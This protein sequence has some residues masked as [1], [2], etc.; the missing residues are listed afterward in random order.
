MK[1]SLPNAV[2]TRVAR[3]VLVAQKHSPKIMF[4]SGLVLMGG[5]VVAACKGTLQLETTLDEVRRDREDVA[6][7]AERHPE[8]YTEREVTKLNAYVTVKGGVRIVKLYL[9][10]IALGVAAVACL[11][12]SHNQLTRR[13]AGLSAALAATERALDGYR[14]RVRESLG[15]D[16]ELELWRGE[17]TETKVVLDDEGRETKSKVKVKTGGGYSPYARVWGRDTS[18]EWDPI[19]EYNLAKLRSVQSWGTIMLNSR[20]HLFLN[21]I[22]DELGL[23]RT[24]AG[25]VVGWLSEKNGGADGFVDF[26]VIGRETDSEEGLRFL[27]FVTGREEH[28]LL[29]FNVDGEIWRNI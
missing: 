9:P 27:D 17:K 8:K 6:L 16:R 5:S 29:D 7:A 24:P 20:G 1:L 22:F 18:N 13:N 26:G 28:I 12:S 3:Q 23:E 19:S 21:E 4:Y 15:E 25:S 11:T 14:N 2:T 10:A